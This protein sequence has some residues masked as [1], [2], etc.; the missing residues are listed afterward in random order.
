MAIHSSGKR[1][2]GIVFYM[3]KQ[4]FDDF[5]KEDKIHRVKKVKSKLD[6]HRKFIYNYASFNKDD[7]A[8]DEILDYA[9]NQ[10]IKRR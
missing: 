6:K 5:D 8:Y 4:K 2:G 7:D 10:K 1:T 9:F 3:S